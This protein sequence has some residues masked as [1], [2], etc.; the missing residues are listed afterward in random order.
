M[1]G[2]SESEQLELHHDPYPSDKKA[3]HRER[4]RKRHLDLL[5]RL[6]ANDAEQPKPTD[7][8]SVWFD[9]KTA[10]KI[11]D[12]GFFNLAEVAQAVARGGRSNASLPGIGEGKAQHIATHLHTLISAVVHLKR[13]FAA[14]PLPMLASPKA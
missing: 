11:V 14:R 9:E 5:P 12:A 6:G 13:A 3:E 2:L 1:N 10:S 8:V 7:I 4:L